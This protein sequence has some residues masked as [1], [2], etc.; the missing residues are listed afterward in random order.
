MARHR[1]AKYWNSP[2]NRVQGC[3]PGCGPSAGAPAAPDARVAMSDQRRRGARSRATRACSP[4]DTRSMPASETIVVYGMIVSREQSAAGFLGKRFAP[5][6]VS[7]PATSRC[8]G[9]HHRHLTARTTSVASTLLS[10]LLALSS[11]QGCVTSS[12]LDDG[13]AA[14]PFLSLQCVVGRAAPMIAS[15]RC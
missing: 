3:L 1:C 12:S 15:A 10:N 11:W 9:S 4:P 7:A 13:R 14:A 2:P 8:S 6:P 5:A